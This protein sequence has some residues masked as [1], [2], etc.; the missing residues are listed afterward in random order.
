MW[1]PAEPLE[2][3]ALF[4]GEGALRHVG[5]SGCHSERDRRTNVQVSQVTSNVSSRS[6]RPSLAWKLGRIFWGYRKKTGLIPKDP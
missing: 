6:L 1:Q 4:F 2:L 5:V 3:R